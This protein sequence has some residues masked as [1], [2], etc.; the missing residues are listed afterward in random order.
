MCPKIRAT[1]GKGLMPD[2]TSRLKTLD[3]QQIFHFMGCSTF[4]EYAVLASISLAKLNPEANPFTCCVL[5]CGIPTGWGAV[6]NN[7]NFHANSSVAVWGLGAVGLAVIQAAKAKGATR[8][9]G[10]DINEKKFEIAKEFGATNCF[11]PK[12]GDTRAWLSSQEKWGIN[13]TYD[14]TGSVA[15]MREALEMAHRGFGESMVIGVAAAGQELATRP[16]QLVTG[17]CWKGTAFGG[18]KSVQDV[19]KLCDKVILG[20]LPIEK[21]VTHEFDGIEKIQELI[22][23]LKGGDCLRGVLKINKYEVPEAPK[24]KVLSN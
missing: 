18:W 12:T 15:V 1:Q 10:I 14:A 24:I 4:A 16:F 6:M 9:Y 22:D 2:G 17:R 21:Y 11:N 3:G 5:G 20:E 13:F 7:P 19:P 8:I 23:A